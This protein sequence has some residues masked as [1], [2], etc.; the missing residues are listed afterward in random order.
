MNYKG[1]SQKKMFVK[2]KAEHPSFSDA[3]VNQIVLDHEKK[4]F[5]D[6]AG[7]DVTPKQ[8]RDYFLKQVTLELKKPSPDYQAV[9]YYRGEIAKIP[10]GY[11]YPVIK[12]N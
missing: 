1:L 9:A 4:S 8:K 7:A 2:E 6:V 11:L 10:R 12:K 3:Q 5:F